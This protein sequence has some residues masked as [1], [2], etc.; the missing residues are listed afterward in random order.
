MKNSLILCVL[1]ATILIT[2]PAFAANETEKGTSTL[3]AERDAVNVEEQKPSMGLMIGTFVP[4]DGN[5]AT[6]NVGID[7]M[8]QPRIPFG[9]GFEAT[10][11]RPESTVTGERLEHTTVLAKAQYN[12]GGTIPVIRSSYVGIGAGAQFQESDT[13]FAAAPIVG[14]DIP[15][16][17]EISHM[18]LG[19]NAKYLYVE[20]NE[21]TDSNATSINGVVKFWY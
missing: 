12:F 8:F 20:G 7:F 1:T 13:Q 18:S 9:F 15:L 16:R 5:V 2:A 11:A 19:A 3:P 17:D 21:D 4:D 6:P 14:F 10:H